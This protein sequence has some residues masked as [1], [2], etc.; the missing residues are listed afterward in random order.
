[1]VY[2]AFPYISIAEDIDEKL[3]ERDA[4]E[5]FLRVERC[6]AI[7]DAAR[8]DPRPS[9]DEGAVYSPRPSRKPEDRAA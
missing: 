2:E 5:L 3:V 6:E 7:A 8:R 9:C 4:L 1:V